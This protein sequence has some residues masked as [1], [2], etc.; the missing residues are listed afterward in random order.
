MHGP[1]ARCALCQTTCARACAAVM[2]RL[3]ACMRNCHV[4]VT[5]LQIITSNYQLE[6][7][8]KT[9]CCLSEV[10]LRAP[11]LV[12]DPEPA[13]PLQ[14]PQDW[15]PQVCWT[16]WRPRAQRVHFHRLV[17]NWLCH[18]C[19]QVY[20]TVQLQLPTPDGY[21]H[22]SA[23]APAPA[24]VFHQQQYYKAD[25]GMPVVSVE[26]CTPPFAHQQPQQSALDGGGVDHIAAFA[27]GGG[28]YDQPAQ[29]AGWEV[30]GHAVGCAGRA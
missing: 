30:P 18:A 29:G 24:A 22:Y 25:A 21:Q 11:I 10:C 8:A 17:L 2:I 3:C 9:G 6:V 16:G 1:G 13:A 15:A 19:M 12:N 23:V 26:P 28:A 27:A 14:P 20:S 7:A 4:V 5:R